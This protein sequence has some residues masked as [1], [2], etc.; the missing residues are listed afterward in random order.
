MS[1]GGD[2]RTAGPARVSTAAAQQLPPA[3]PGRAAWGTAG[4]LRAWQAAAL[5]TYLEREPRDFLAVATPG[6]GKTTFALRVAVELL[7]RGVV[8]KLTIV[9]PTEH[10]KGQWADAAARVGIHVDPAFTNSQGRAGSHFDGVAVTYAQ[11]AA[12][13]TLHAARTRAN[14]T[15][16]ILD[17][18]HHAGLPVLG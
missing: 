8:S 9:C 7:G 13:P 15:L 11:V 10:L 17:E 2:G 12:N 6:A 1:R 18:V 14:P 16:V 3:F 5:E 4:N